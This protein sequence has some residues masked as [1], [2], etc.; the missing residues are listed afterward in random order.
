MGADLQAAQQASSRAQMTHGQPP[1]ASAAVG[2][3]RGMKDP[4]DAG[5]QMLTHVLPQGM[6]NAGN[7]ANNWLADTTGMVG[8]IPPGGLDAM[9]AQEEAKYQQGRQTAGRSGF[10]AA[11]MGG[12]VASLVAPMRAIPMASTM[13]GRAGASAG[14]LGRLCRAESRPDED[15]R[16]DRIAGNT[17]R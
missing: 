11:R 7:A 13:V 16:S 1:N 3:M 17:T 5:A 8:K 4:V 2:F 15:R 9:L 6:V 14:L 12:N 10:D